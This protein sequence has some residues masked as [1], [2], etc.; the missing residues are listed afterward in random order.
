MKSVFILGDTVSATTAMNAVVFLKDFGESKSERIVLCSNSVDELWR[1]QRCLDVTVAYD[2][3]DIDSI[4]NGDGGAVP[5]CLGDGADAKIIAKVMNNKNLEYVYKA[6]TKPGMFLN[7]RADADYSAS[8]T[9]S[10]Y[11][12]MKIHNLRDGG[13]NRFSADL[14]E[15]FDQKAA[16]NVK[17]GDNIVADAVGMLGG[18][19]V[20]AIID[21]INP[22]ITALKVLAVKSTVENIDVIVITENRDIWNCGNGENYHTIRKNE[23]DMVHAIAKCVIKFTEDTRIK[24][25]GEYKDR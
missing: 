6:T 11:E 24:V 17:F 4:I 1:I 23:R 14:E 7:I 5:I 19:Q 15:F 2:D 12:W 18:Q 13:K 22:V 10:I 25:R 9:L 16:F 20:V 21:D 3:G 8:A